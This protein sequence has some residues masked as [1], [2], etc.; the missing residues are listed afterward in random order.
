MAYTIHKSPYYLFSLQL[1][2]TAALQTVRKTSVLD[3]MRR[4]LQSKNVMVSAHARSKEMSNS[5]YLSILNVIQAS[6]WL[7]TYQARER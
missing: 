3:V 6:P 1:I 4:L 2:F 5:K 7:F